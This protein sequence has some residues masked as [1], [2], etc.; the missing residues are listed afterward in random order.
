MKVALGFALLS[1]AAVSHGPDFSLVGTW[2]GRLNIV[3]PPLSASAPASLRR[4]RQVLLDETRNGS[5][6]LRMFRDHRYTIESVGLKSFGPTRSRG[7][8]SKR[9]D[10][11]S[12]TPT[13]ASRYYKFLV[14][15]GKRRMTASAVF[16][17]TTAQFVFVR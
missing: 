6:T 1:I 16:G 17:R 7:I 13:G 15:P 9:G 8:W 4:E 12:L 10:V 14:A 11:L 2:T 3:T 5:L